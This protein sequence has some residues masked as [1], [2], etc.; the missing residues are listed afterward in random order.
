MSIFAKTKNNEFTYNVKS[1]ILSKDLDKINDITCNVKSSKNNKELIEINKISIIEEYITYHNKYYKKYGEEMIVLMQVGSFYE[2]YGTETEGPNVHKISELINI[3]CTRKD[4]KEKII[5]IKNPYMIGFPTISMDKYISLLVSNGYTI[6]MIDQISIPPNVQR[7]VTNII[8]PSTYIGTISTVE[9]NYIISIYCEYEKQRNDNIRNINTLLCIGMTAIDITTGK[10]IVYETYSTSIDN[11]IALDDTIRFITSIQPKEIIIIRK[12]DGKMTNE[13][14]CNYL[15]IDKKRIQIITYNETYSKITYQNELLK[16]IYE[17]EMNMISPIEYL[18]LE[19]NNYIRISLIYCINFLLEHNEKLTNCLNIPEIFA[20]NSR[21]IL[22]NN[23]IYQ[24]NV[25]EIEKYNYVIN[26]K[27][28]SLYDV[29]NNATTGM[30]KRYIKQMLLSPYVNDIE[31]NKQYDRVE[32][33]IKEKRYIMVEKILLYICDIEKLKRKMNLNIIQPY[34]MADMITSYTQVK[35]LITLLTEIKLIDIIPEKKII[36]KLEEFNKEMENIFDIEILKI[37]ILNN[38]KTS[39]F[40]KGIY[41]EIDE[42]VGE[43]IIGKNFIEKI[44]LYFEKIIENKKTSGITI[45]STKTEGV[46]IYMSIK[47]YQLIMTKLENIKKYE[48][49][50]NI[51]IN[52]DILIIKQ[53]KSTIKMFINI[54][55]K[56]KPLGLDKNDKPKGVESLNLTET[57]IDKEIISMEE[58]ISKIVHK[59]YIERIYNIYTKYNNMFTSII[60]FITLID[61]TNSSAKTATIYNYIRPTIIKKE[62][63]Y[64]NVENIRHP[65]VERIIDYEY[66]P[67]NIELGD[68]MK[69]ILLYGLNSA[70]KSVLMKAIG[71][72][73]ILAQAGMYVPATK[74]VLS[75]YNSLYTRITGD[76]NIFRGLSSFS[77]EMVELNTILKRANKKTLIIGDEVC[78]GT[79]HISGNAIVAS[80]IVRLSSLESTFIFATHLHEL[81]SLKCIKELNKVKAYHLS[82]EYDEQKDILIYDRK[83]KE[84]S[85]DNIYGI[86]VAKH[87]IQDKEFIKSTLNIKNELTNSYKTIISDKTSRYNSKLYVYKCEICGRKDLNGEFSPLET[88]HINYQKN[89]INGFSINKPHIQK[90]SMANL[91]V[92]CQ[93]CHDKI[94]NNEI[95]VDGYVMTSSGKKI[96]KN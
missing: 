72:T 33:V 95:A 75:P 8:S 15:Q 31:I 39:F 85:G 48:I 26:N 89:C 47:K 76:D 61:Y 46:Y 21:L 10:N 38:I 91:I 86:N 2:A 88:H 67:H 71:L 22:G 93:T 32:K 34:E 7:K 20:D 62:E 29:V 69:G 64:I 83:L 51:P 35:E 54:I 92:I 65:V 30:G 84:G 79:E 16:N 28:H 25:I 74:C 78:R 17:S 60:R 3:V 94:H 63:G 80:T 53:L 68:K 49:I 12:G 6:I 18:E 43:S 87:I 37:N 44:V 58:R 19:K 24:L 5:N 14:I 59:Y 96:I 50:D 1:S 82:T 66:I 13:M 4:K 81:I 23:A 57:K 52:K 36:D 11:E 41:K 77:L 90:N 70:G 42:I 27:I 73:I 55:N 40:K 9:T 45:K 56:N